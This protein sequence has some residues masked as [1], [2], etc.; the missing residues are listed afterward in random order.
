[1]EVTAILKAR[2][3]ALVYVDELNLSGK[4]RFFDIVSPLVEKYG[5]LIYPSKPEDFDP[6]KGIKFGSGKRGDKV[7][8]LLAFFT[9]LISLE[10]LS[11]TAD[12]RAILEEMLVWGR[13]KLGL[14]Y[15][16][17]TVRHWAYI[18]QVSFNTDFPLL[19]LLSKPLQNLGRKTGEAVSG[20]FGETVPYELTKVNVGH[21]PAARK[22]AIAGITIDRRIDVPFGENRFFSEAP[23]PT[24]LHIKFLQEFE[25][26]VLKSIK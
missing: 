23:L 15:N 3:V 12:S 5:F 22:N 7:I 26:E 11:S 19:S 8:D 17:G 2:A 9:G 24:E 14:T 21:D 6:E 4:L 1:M 25:A 16:A 13:E 10:T 18:S 20:F